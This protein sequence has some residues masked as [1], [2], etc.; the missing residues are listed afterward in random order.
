MNVAAGKNVVEL[1]QQQLL[2]ARPQGVGGIG[3]AG[4]GR[5]AAADFRLP[6]LELQHTV[7][8]L[9]LALGGEGAPVHLQVQFA[10]PGSQVGVALQVLV[11][12]RR[13][14]GHFRLGHDAQ[15]LE[16]PCHLQH[17]GGA[18]AAAVAVAEHA[19]GL[20]A[21]LL[22]LVALPVLL[23]LAGHVPGDEV[24]GRHAGIH[25]GAVDALPEEVVVG[26]A[27]GIVP[28]GHLV[29]DEVIHAALFQDLRQDPAVA[30][31]VRQ[32]GVVD[33]L[34][35]GTAKEVLTI[36][37]LTNQALGSR[38]V[39][40]RLHIHGAHRLE[41]ALGHLLLQLREQLGIILLQ[42][43]I[44]V[45]LGVGV[46]EL[47]VL[48]QEAQLNQDGAGVLLHRVDPPPVVG[49]VQVAVT[50]QG[51]VAGAL[52]VGV[53]VDVL[54][55]IGRR[56]R[57]ALEGVEVHQ[58]QGVAQ[59]HKEELAVILVE[60]LAVGDVHQ[61]DVVVHQALHVL[62]DG[63]QVRPVK[64]L[65]AAPG[66]NG[67]GVAL[68]VGLG[69]VVGLDLDVQLG[70]IANVWLQGHQFPVGVHAA[71]IG[72]VDLHDH[73]RRRVQG[74]V[75]LLSPQM[76]G[77][78]HMPLDEG[79]AIGGE[80]HVALV[81]GAVVLGV[82][83][84]LVFADLPR[85]PDGQIGDLELLVI[86]AALQPGKAQLRPFLRPHAAADDL[87][88]CHRRSPFPLPQVSWKYGLTRTG[89]IRTVCPR[90]L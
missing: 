15:L 30:E 65:P 33:G 36:E 67:G 38:H 66:G 31:H 45:G 63:G 40:V 53:G 42:R 21:H 85:I 72:A 69:A 16:A 47:R 26:E 76:L 80:D 27:V 51:H 41:A 24:G 23:D 10:V 56:I 77:D 90:S 8:P 50:H 1:V 86:N 18:A 34:A 3:P 4:Q 55:H 73:L 29:G 20:S 81:Q 88:M 75:Q 78:G 48:I 64:D 35:E 58:I 39:A 49:D 37:Q 54:L 22:V 52:V 46:A 70:C 9:Q 82:V 87:Y 60:V 11:Q 59:L 25:A 12:E 13:T 89:T 2:V 71:H 6:Q 68:V 83:F 62:P 84:I 7:Q 74:E 32:P 14:A 5:Q 57:N 28:G 43:F 44:G 17:L 19:Q 61:Q 79:R